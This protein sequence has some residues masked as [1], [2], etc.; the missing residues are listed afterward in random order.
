MICGVYEVKILGWVFKFW[1]MVYE[2]HIISTHKKKYY[3]I[4]E[5]YGKQKH[6]QIIQHALK[7]QYISLLHK[8]IK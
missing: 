7:I 6:C 4:S 8:Y 1:C 3:E 2:N 5:F